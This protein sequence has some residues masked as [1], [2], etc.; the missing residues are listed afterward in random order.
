MSKWLKQK[1]QLAALLFLVLCL[2][3]CGEQEQ[4][5]VALGQFVADVK[6]QPGNPIASALS[7][8]DYQPHEYNQQVTRSPFKQLDS[9][10]AVTDANAKLDLAR[11]KSILESFPLDTLRMVGTLT[12]ANTIWVLVLAPDGIVYRVTVGEYIGQQ[13]GKIVAVTENAM[14]V[15][16]RIAVANGTGQEQAH[17]ISI[18]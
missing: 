14:K 2:S 15:I 9:A 3:A 7:Y 1:I 10:Q 8:D 5:R 16:E 11:Q 13:N 17:T 6:K 18:N 12:H 4:K